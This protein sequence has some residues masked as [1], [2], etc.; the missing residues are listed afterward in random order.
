MSGVKTVRET[1]FSQ[2][3]SFDSPNLLPHLMLFH[4]FK[5]LTLESLLIS[6]SLVTKTLTVLLNILLKYMQELDTW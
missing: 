5:I 6:L 3:N 4:R 2:I 1:S